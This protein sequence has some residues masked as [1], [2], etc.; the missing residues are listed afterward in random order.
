[1]NK[2][3]QFVNNT[4]HVFFA[5][6]FFLDELREHIE[7]FPHGNKTFAH[8]NKSNV[9][10]ENLH[11]FKHKYVS[12]SLPLWL[13]A[14]FIE[15]EDISNHLYTPKESNHCVFSPA[16]IYKPEKGKRSLMEALMNPQDLL[17]AYA[18]TIHK[19][20]GLQA[21]PTGEGKANNFYDRIICDPGARD[22]ESKN[23]GLLYTVC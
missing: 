3:T 15:Q 10:E 7:K 2:N 1:M 4:N 19:F 21:G 6:F 8:L 9:N 11:T 18:K 5:F 14:G 16:S 20:Q 22:F 17:L 13:L 23:P 12:D